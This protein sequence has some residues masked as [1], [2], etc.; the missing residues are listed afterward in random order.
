MLLGVALAK[1]P[2]FKRETADRTQSFRLTVQIAFLLLNVWIGTQ[3]YFFVR[4]YERYA[5]AGIQRP[6]GVEGWL[7]IAGLMNLK[8]F[9]STGIV[10]EIHPAAMVLVACFL[11]MSWLLRKAFCGWLCPVGTISEYLWKLGRKLFRRNIVVP[12][13]ADIPLRGLK[14]LLMALF[15]YA[16][17]T[18]PVV[19]ILLFLESPY[20]LVA[21]VKKAPS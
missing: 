1:K 2:Y 16:V 5:P 10:P 17:V 9:L 12:K 19:S 7:P 14:Y 15:L 11:L 6:P 18:M 4:Q 3:F 21:D 20:G 8:A 13:W